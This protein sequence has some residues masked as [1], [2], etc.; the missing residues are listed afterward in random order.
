MR[1]TPELK[2]GQGSIC[3]T[4]ASGVLGWNL[5]RFFQ[6]AGW[7]VEATHHLQQPELPGVQWHVLDLADPESIRRF[8]RTQ[9]AS[10]LVHTA[11]MSSPQEC[12]GSPAQAMQVNFEAT[13]LLV[14]SCRPETRV[15]FFSTDLVFD[16]S[17]GR[18]G[19]NDPPSPTGV[20]AQSKHMAEAAVL[21][22]SGAV[23]VR[24]AKIYALG[25]PFSG[26]FLTWMRDRFEAGQFVPL[27]V[28]E[29]RSPIFVGDVCRAV[30]QLASRRVAF[31]LYH[32]G[33]PL[34]LSRYELGRRF[35]ETWGYPAELIRPIRL[36]QMPGM[37][38]PPD[39]SLDSSRFGLEFDFKWTPLGEGLKRLKGAVGGPDS[40]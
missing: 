3:I 2:P 14:E 23:V 27:F 10:I 17:R 25:S 13:R 24:L 18:Y 20:Y 28:D 36:D 31:P 39:C 15:I 1:L 16:G 32:L 7:S 5:C 4:G 22:R 35:A 38:R 19:E 6:A 26:C 8:C 34:R 37:F 33:G 30:E 29:F 11:A 12:Q 21:N 9:T 40:C